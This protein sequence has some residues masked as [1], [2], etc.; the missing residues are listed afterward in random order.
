MDF[1]VKNDDS[2]GTNW[3]S[4]WETNNNRDSSE[5]NEI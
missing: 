4:K 3:I 1:Q 5:T 2:E